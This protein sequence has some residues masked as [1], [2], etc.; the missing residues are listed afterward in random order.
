V[1]VYS[2]V[3]ARSAWVGISFT[4]KKEV[5]M[6]VLVILAGLALSLDSFNG[7]SGS[8]SGSHLRSRMTPL[9]WQ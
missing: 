1:I 8:P 3:E 2:V 7:H 6:D 9:P 4:L 5:V